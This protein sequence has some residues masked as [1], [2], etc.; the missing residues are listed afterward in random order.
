LQLNPYGHNPCVTSSLRRRWACLL[1][2]CLAFV[3]YTYRTCSTLLKR[4]S[5]SH[6]TTDDQSV[7]ESWFRPRLGLMTRC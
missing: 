6:I 1:W 5:Q 2:I 4:Q 7:S 3:K